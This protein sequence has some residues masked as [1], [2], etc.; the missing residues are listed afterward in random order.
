M[1]DTCH[2][3]PRNRAPAR[4][5]R[6]AGAL[7]VLAGAAC[8]APRAAEPAPAPAARAQGAPPRPAP[9]VSDTTSAAALTPPDPL[10]A[11]AAEVVD[12]QHEAYNRHDLD[13]F[14]ASYA[15]S[16]A[17]QTLG[18]SVPVIGKAKLRADTEAWFAEA[19]E[20]RTELM[21]RM[22]GPFVV[23]RQRVSEGTGGS[24]VEAID[25]YEVREGLIRRVWSIPPPPTPR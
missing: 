1:R 25:I 24:T 21:D 5:V 16:V 13:G 6:R 2:T 10:A 8:A 22:L 23:D 11:E 3:T 12:R 14:L 7:V 17:V 20:A 18:D 4:L 19:P 9:P 15:D